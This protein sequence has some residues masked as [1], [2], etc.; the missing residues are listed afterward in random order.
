MPKSVIDYS[1]TIIYKIVCKDPNVTDLYVGHTTSFNTRKYQ[2][3]IS[4]SSPVTSHTKIYKVINENGGWDNWE[5]LEI[6]TYNCKDATEA[7]IKENQH[8]EELKATLNTVSPYMDKSKYY[9]EKCNLQLKNSKQYENHLLSKKHL[10]DVNLNEEV[11]NNKKYLCELCNFIC[12]KNSN[13]QMHLQTQKHIDNTNE[14]KIKIETYNCICGK[15]YTDRSGL[16]RHKKI[17]NYQ[18]EDITSEEEK[19]EDLHMIKIIKQNNEFKEV[20]INLVNQ[21]NELIKQNNEFK[22]LLVNLINKK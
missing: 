18:E 20:I 2:H 17:C 16:W 5:M 19:N 7:R 4:C 12:Y 10:N 21:N 14:D 22:E 9:C 1:N 11:I 13:Y 15:I 6:A 8:Y 3:K